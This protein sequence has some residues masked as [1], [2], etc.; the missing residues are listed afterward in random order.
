[1]AI[2]LLVLNGIH[3][4]EDIKDIAKSGDRCLDAKRYGKLKNERPTICEMFLKFDPQKTYWTNNRVL[5]RV[6]ATSLKADK[7]LNN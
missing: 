7:K 6:C 1:M 2:C 5:C 4:K 3:L